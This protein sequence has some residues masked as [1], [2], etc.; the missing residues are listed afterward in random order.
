VGDAGVIEYPLC[1]GRLSRIDVSHDA[2]IS[3]MLFQ[4]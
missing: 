1:G 3:G 2:N 4:Q